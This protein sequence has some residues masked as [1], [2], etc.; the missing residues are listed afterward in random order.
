M[1][2]APRK[3]I[4]PIHPSERSLKASFLT[5]CVDSGIVHKGWC[6]SSEYR[7]DGNSRRADLAALG[8]GRFVGIEFKSAR[9][10][11]KRLAGQMDAYLRVFDQVILVVAEKHIEQA[12]RQTPLPVTIYVANQSGSLNLARNGETRIGGSLCN[13][14]M[15]QN[16]TKAEIA[17]MTGIGDG[18]SSRSQLL[19][20]ADEMPTEKV[21]LG[22]Q[23]AFQKRY[24]NTSN[25]FWRRTTGKTI[26]IE[27]LDYL[28]RYAKRRKVWQK[29]KSKNDKFWMDWT[30]KA[31]LHFQCSNQSSHSSSVSYF[32]SGSL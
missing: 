22:M 8:D 28:S 26:K 16:L 1:S 9:D 5:H 30:K 11:V 3:S 15:A 29:H 13:R 20:I 23:A 19:T 18:R 24:E 25:M 14:T 31:A 21:R 4:V 6:L 12:L 10:T 32:S 2:S 27:H 17:E 7:I